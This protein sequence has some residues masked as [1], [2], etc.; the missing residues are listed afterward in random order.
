MDRHRAVRIRIGRNVA[1]VHDI[2]RTHGQRDQIGRERPCR[3]EHRLRQALARRTVIGNGRVRDHL[4]GA[5][6]IHRHGEGSLESRLVEGGKGAARIGR[7]ELRERILLGAVGHLVEAGQRL[8]ER[9]VIIEDQRCR[10]CGYDLREQQPRDSRRMHLLVA[11]RNG[12]PGCQAHDHTLHMQVEPIEI[13]RAARRRKFHIDL[14]MPCETRLGGI[15][16]ECEPVIGGRHDARQHRHGD[17]AG[18][19]GGLLPCRVA[20][21]RS[22][23]L[24]G[25]STGR[26][27]NDK[28]EGSENGKGSH[29][30]A[31]ETGLGS[32]H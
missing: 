20:R 12:L 21:R 18:L 10:A 3:R 32:I 5:G 16:R 19:G 26:N 11:R 27:R 31:L 1:A 13:N 4:V 23:R 8:A 22:F 30:G 15:D 7:F 2:E 17:R 9:R 29:G 14:V 28:C 6:R 25:F 24:I